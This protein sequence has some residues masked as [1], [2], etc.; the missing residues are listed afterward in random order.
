MPFAKVVWFAPL[1][2]TLSYSEWH[3]V[4]QAHLPQDAR[5]S[6]ITYRVCFKHNRLY[7]SRRMSWELRIDDLPSHQRLYLE[8]ARC[9]RCTGEHL[10]P[11]I[12]DREEK[13][14][15]HSPR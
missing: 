11:R 7:H 6:M 9:D 12:D 15:P 4:L 5:G 13:A 14:R 2:I 10:A 3:W 1:A 8:A